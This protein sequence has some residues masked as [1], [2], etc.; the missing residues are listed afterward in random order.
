MVTTVRP[1]RF[2]ATATNVN[3]TSAVLD[4]DGITVLYTFD[5]TIEV[6]DLLV[7]PAYENQPTGVLPIAYGAI[8]ATTVQLLY[9]PGELSGSDPM[10]IPTD[11][12]AIRTPSAGFVN[13]EII[14]LT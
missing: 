13:A 5:G 12:P 11:D 7:L 2:E 14:E 3:C 10:I 1:G 6:P 4:V 8:T 9:D